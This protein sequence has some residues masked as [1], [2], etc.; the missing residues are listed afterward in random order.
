MDQFNLPKRAMAYHP[1]VEP[2]MK[3]LRNLAY[4]PG[5]QP[6]VQVQ[7]MV[8]KTQVELKRCLDQQEAEISSLKSEME[9]KDEDIFAARFLTAELKIDNNRK[10]EEI[11]GLRKIIM[12]LLQK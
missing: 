11:A 3:Q 12:D 1:G 7:P 5:V 4:H 2:P 10:D 9:R 8:D 6:V